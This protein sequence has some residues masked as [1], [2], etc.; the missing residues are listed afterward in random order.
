MRW[1]CSSEYPWM[2]GEMDIII[3]LLVMNPGSWFTI[4]CIL[5]TI[6]PATTSRTKESATCDETSTFLRRERLPNPGAL[7]FSAT[8]RSGFDPCKAGARENNT[9]VSKATISVNASTR[10][11]GLVSTLRSV[12]HSRQQG[13]HQR[14]RQHAGVRTCVHVAQRVERL[15]ESKN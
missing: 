14:E 13:H 10:V 6:T 5:R 8:T 11:S 7:S 1:A 9:P 15:A 3:K 4:F 12:Q 2:L